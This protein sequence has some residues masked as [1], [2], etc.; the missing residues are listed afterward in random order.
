MKR[1]CK[2][3][4]WF[5]DQSGTGNPILDEC[6]CLLPGGGK[7]YFLDLEPCDDFDENPD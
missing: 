6:A 1:T 5:L 2:D 7:N 4:G 3:C